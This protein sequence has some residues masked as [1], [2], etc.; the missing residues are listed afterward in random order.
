MAS[1]SA[2]P[3]LRLQFTSRRPVPAL[4]TDPEK[5]PEWRAARKAVA[6]CFSVDSMRRVFVLGQQ[7]AKKTV[8][9]IEEE[10]KRGDAQAR[11]VDVDCV[12]QRLMLDIFADWGEAGCAAGVSSICSICGKTSICRASSI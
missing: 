12:M 7:Y 4:F 11:G 1:S 3:A 9:L 8:L 5:T 6:A 2:D 10:G